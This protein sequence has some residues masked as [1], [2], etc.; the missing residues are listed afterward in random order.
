MERHLN[1]QRWLKIVCHPRQSPPTLEGVL[2]KITAPYVCGIWLENV[3][4]GGAWET[5]DTAWAHLLLPRVCVWSMGMIEG[6]IFFSL[7]F[8]SVFLFSVY[9]FEC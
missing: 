8:L 6:G 2:L 4:L 1:F 7:F 3:S 9:F 5:G